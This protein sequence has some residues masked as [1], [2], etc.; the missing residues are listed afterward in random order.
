MIGID[1][2]TITPVDIHGMAYAYV[3]NV[4]ATKL[5]AIYPTRSHTARVVAQSLYAS[6]APMD[7]MRPLPAIQAV[8]SQLKYN[9]TFS[10]LDKLI[11]PHLWTD[12][13][14]IELEST[15]DKSWCYYEP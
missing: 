6:V 9:N 4:F 3:I 15:T 14:P 2:L 5:V 10:G 13:N 1:G 7:I 8:T 11:A 12:T